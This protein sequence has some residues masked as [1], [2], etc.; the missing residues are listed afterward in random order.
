MCAEGPNVSRIKESKVER[1]KR[2]GRF[3]RGSITE[4]LASEAQ[5]FA[6]DDV[7]LLKFHGVYQQED[8]DARA[9]RRLTGKDT[10]TR[11]MIRS[12]IPGGR[13]NAD[14]YLTFDRLAEQV[15]YN[16]SLRITTRQTLQLHGVIKKELRATIAGIHRSLVTTLAA[17]GDIG[18]NVMAPPAPRADPTYRALRTL[19]DTISDALAPRT[20]AYSEIWL[21]GER[22]VDDVEP[23]YGASYL[24]R[25]FKVGIALPEDNAVDVYTQD[26]G[27][28]AVTQDEGPAS[29]LRGVDVV[30]GGGL[31]LTHRKADTFARLASPLGFVTAEQAPI[32]V[33]ALVGLFR[34]HGER[35]D[36]K[37]ARLKYLI[38]DWGPERFRAALEA[39]LPFSIAPWVEVGKLAY[40]DW[41]GRHEQGDGRV[42]YGVHIPNGRIIDTPEARLKSALAETVAAVRPGVVL[43][44]TQNL[45]LTDLTPENAAVV[46][47]ILSAYGAAP[48]ALSPLRR[49]AMACPALPTC[50]LAL[51]ESER[52]MPQLLDA[53]EPALAAR[54]LEHET[55]S[56]R[57]TGCPNGCARPYAADLGIVGRRAGHYDLYVGGRLSGDRLAFLWTEQVAACGI[58]PAL[59]PLLD[60]WAE[61]R[62]GDEGLGEL[63][64]R[65]FAGDAPHPITTGAKQP[66]ASDALVSLTA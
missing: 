27:L 11:F 44:P 65:L 15:S 31:G 59:E 30:V 38:E 20:H 46:A 49:Y 60:L 3:L 2:G 40:R 39:R 57:M 66:A 33:C 17:C 51:A 58:V 64:R 37:H 12:R 32:L 16:R 54:G 36:R 9:V 61:E 34:D 5:A 29:T 63:A 50:G 8:R 53:L 47:Q 35:G 21:D 19:A 24:P 28:I 55:I 48:R 23:L 26:V 10:P 25:K 18:R 1:A 62:R 42:F 43:T 56:I 14:Q 41:L 4:V 7:Q 22:V 6:H 52:F 45:L 13:L